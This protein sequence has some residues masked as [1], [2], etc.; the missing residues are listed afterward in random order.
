MDLYYGQE[1]FLGKLLFL[2]LLQFTIFL[3]LFIYNKDENNIE[4]QYP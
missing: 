4:I 2:Q 1:N 3:H